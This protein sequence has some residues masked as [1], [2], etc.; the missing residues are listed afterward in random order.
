MKTAAAAWPCGTP[1]LISRRLR[2][3]PP[4][5]SSSYARQDGADQPQDGEDEADQAEDPVPLTERHHREGEDED[6]V[7]NAEADKP[8]HED[9]SIRLRRGDW[10]IGVGLVGE[11]QQGRQDTLITRGL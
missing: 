9:T 4:G 2:C 1:A 3:P 6:E 10:E 11:A 8:F 7:Q 5:R